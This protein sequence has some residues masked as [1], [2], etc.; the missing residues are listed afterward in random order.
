MPFRPN[1]PCGP[2]SGFAS[3]ASATINLKLEHTL[4]SASQPGIGYQLNA[5]LYR[6]IQPDGDGHL[7]LDGPAH[8]CFDR[9]AGRND[10]AESRQLQRRLTLRI[11]SRELR[12]PLTAA[13]GL[14]FLVALALTG[15]WAG[16]RQHGSTRAYAPLEPTH[17]T[18]KSKSATSSAGAAAHLPVGAAVPG[19][20]S[21][22]GLPPQAGQII[23]TDSG[24]VFRGDDGGVTAFPLVGPVRH[25][26]TRS[27]R[28]ATVALAYM[29]RTNGRPAY[30]FRIDAGVF[31]TD[32]PGPLLDLAAH[33]DWLDSVA[34][35]E[36][37]AHRPLVDPT[38]SVALWRATRSIA[39]SAYA[40]TLYTLFGQPRAPIG[41]IG[42]RGRSAG[43][44]GEYISAY[45]SLALD[46][47]RMTGMAQLRHALAHE[48]AHRW[49]ARAPGQLAVLWSG[50]TPIRD[51]K[52]YGF[53]DQSEHQAEAVAFAINFLQTTARSPHDQSN[54]ITLLDHYE[55]LVPGTRTM[56]RYLSL[57]PLYR[58]HPLRPL[59][60]TG[61]FSAN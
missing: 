53:G 35:R 37:P 39:R 8:R 59:L 28:T 44:L 23:L 27:W 42:G 19:Y 29:D 15:C 30:L 38:D 31:E 51:P 4:V 3:P 10:L 33:P 6:R 26:A 20:L 50:V 9:R 49:Q 47:A 60:T 57:Q 25:S 13:G 45:D 46:P 40:D 11:R 36:W 32:Q 55:F 41:L 14:R 22:R 54:A 48:L 24:L 21:D 61:H 56:V 1:T 34:S 58:R 5:H 43:R 7:R 52:R 16:N 2:G 17:D 18:L 12:S